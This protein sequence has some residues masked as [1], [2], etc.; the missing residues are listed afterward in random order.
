L[1]LT[2]EGEL[3]VM[4]PTGGEAG[5]LN[6]LLYKDLLLWNER[7]QLGVGFNSSTILALPNG[8]MRSP[9]FAW[10]QR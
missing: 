7:S 10:V 3:I 8:A 2:A 9:D 4:P 6:F 5:N 1:E